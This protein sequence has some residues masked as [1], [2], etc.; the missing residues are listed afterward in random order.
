MGGYLIESNRE[1]GDGRPDLVIRDASIRG[2]AMLFEL[3]VSPD[4]I[5]LEKSSEEAIVQ[6]REKGY[7]KGMEGQGYKKICG[8][9]VAF[10]RK[11]CMVKKLP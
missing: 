1:E 11:D 9:G 2:Q 4:P 5:T 7:V 10:Y 3:K 6:I 8:Y